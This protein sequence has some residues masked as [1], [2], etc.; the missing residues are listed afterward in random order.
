MERNMRN[1]HTCIFV[2]VLCF[3]IQC[4][5]SFP[6][7][8]A[9]SGLSYYTGGEGKI[10][11]G[12]FPSKTE[13]SITVTGSTTQK[14]LLMRVD[15]AGGDMKKFMVPVSEDGTF[16][17]IWLFKAGPGAYTVIFF[18]SPQPG[19]MNYAGIAYAK[20]N[21]TGTV[22]ADYPGMALN[23]KIIAFVNTVMGKQVGRGECWDLAQEALDKNMADW[24]RPFTFGTP[25]DINKEPVMPGDII[26]FTSV[27]IINKRPNGVIET[28]T[29]GMPHHTAII[30]EV[31]GRR[32]FKCAHQN[33]ADSRVVLVTEINLANMT[34]GQV[35]VYRPV[36]AAVI[37]PD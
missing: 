22:P 17:F 36:A 1:K 8:S 37:P 31:L 13:Y 27:K 9:G 15:K 18:G 3:V 12:A 6:V 19:A 11:L 24:T 25:V 23:E 26:Q 16:R 30:Y 14:T 5:L 33:I 7:L 34:S 28:H 35:R 29:L 21:V 32:H 20:I 4:V 2:V 10:S